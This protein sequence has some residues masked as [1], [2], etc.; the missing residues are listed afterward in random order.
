MTFYNVISAVLF[1]GAFRELLASIQI[2]DRSALMRAAV[3]ALLVFN[4]AIYTSW[5]IET[6]N[7]K[8]GPS[9]M[10]IDL[11]NFTLLAGALIFLNPTANNIFQLELTSFKQWLTESMFW[12]LLGV[13]WILILLWTWKAGVYS[14]PNYPRWLIKWAAL[15][16]VLF[17]L[18]SLL[19]AVLPGPISNMGRL[20]AAAYPAIYILGLRN[21]TL[22]AGLDSAPVAQPNP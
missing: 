15:I 9:L 18:E 11:I 12:L 5:T 4:D 6:R 14:E 3:L 13:Y 22:R 20:L 21:Y 7:K 17:F 8:Y 10:L 2:G 19:V 16:A 1:L